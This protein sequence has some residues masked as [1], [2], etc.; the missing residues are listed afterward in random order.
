MKEA[1][2]LC[3]CLAGAAALYGAD[4]GICRY[5]F[6]SKTSPLRRVQLSILA[7]PCPEAV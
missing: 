1:L 4:D 2:W 3:A 7:H 5:D 6:G